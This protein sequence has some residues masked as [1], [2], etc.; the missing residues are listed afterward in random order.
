MGREYYTYIMKATQDGI[1]SGALEREMSRDYLA[2]NAKR[3]I[4]SFWSVLCWR[5]TL[6]RHVLR[7]WGPSEEILCAELLEPDAHRRLYNRVSEHHTK[8]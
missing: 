2:G 4:V 3:G 5:F 8:S 6:C 7:T 1:A